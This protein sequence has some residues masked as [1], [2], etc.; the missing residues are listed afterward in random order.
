M[1]EHVSTLLIRILATLYLSR[2]RV[3]EMVLVDD[4]SE[5]E[6]GVDKDWAGD[7]INIVSPW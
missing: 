4:E 2:L 6:D 5:A 1:F 3:W 7:T